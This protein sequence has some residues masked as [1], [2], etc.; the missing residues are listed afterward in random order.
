M[1]KKKR[2]EVVI[3][4]KDHVNNDCAIEFVR[5]MH[6]ILENHPDIAFIGLIEVP[7]EENKGQ[8]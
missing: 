4:M 5:Y 2:F 3:G 1:D 6:I 8:D 7:V